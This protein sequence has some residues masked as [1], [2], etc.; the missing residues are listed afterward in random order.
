[1]AIDK[2]IEWCILWTE[3]CL[4]S[5]E[6]AAWAQAIFSALAVLAAIGVVWWQVFIAKQEDSRAA[7]LVA[8]GLLTLMD[9]VIAGLQIVESGL[10]ERSLGNNSH[11]N[12]PHNLAMILDTLPLPNKEELLALNAELHECAVSLLRA[13]NSARQIRDALKV[14]A[15]ATTPNALEEP[16]KEL[17]KLPHQLA[18]DAR[19]NFLEAREVLNKYCPP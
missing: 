1:M 3:L 18:S 4:P 8:S 7:R 19:K 10:K 2:S 5:S 12:R 11:A 15:N 17:F 16:P 13:S 14:L 9:Q 6:W